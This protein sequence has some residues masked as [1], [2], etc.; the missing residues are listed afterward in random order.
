M[1]FYF[2][3]IDISKKPEH[4]NYIYCILSIFLIYSIFEVPG[5]HY[6]VWHIHRCLFSV[7][8]RDSTI[9]WFN[10]FRYILWFPNLTEPCKT[11][12]NVEISIYSHL[13]AFS[14]KL[15]SILCNIWI[16]LDQRFKFKY[17]MAKEEI[18]LNERETEGFFSNT[19]QQF[20]ISWLSH[21][22]NRK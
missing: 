10:A 17:L 2:I 12:Y 4:F 7:C 21:V 19:H 22:G 3:W 20:K 9:K 18:N 13:Y 16:A 14:E 8:L 1:Y 6:I 11:H 15:I 5:A